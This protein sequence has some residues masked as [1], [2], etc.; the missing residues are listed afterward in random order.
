MKCLR[1]PL[2]TL[3]TLTSCAYRSGGADNDKSDQPIARP[4][5]SAQTAPV[6]HGGDAADDPA[7]WIHPTDPT[8][9]LVLGTDKQGPLVV[10]D[11]DGRVL[12][13]VSETARPDNV[14]VFYD[15]PL[16]GGKADLAV[17]ACRDPKSLGLK[18]WRIDPA[19]RTLADVTAN[20]VIPVFGKTEPYG[21]GTYHSRKTGKHYVFVN[22]KKGQ[23]EQYEL[24]DAGDGKVG[25]KLVRQFKVPS[26]TEGCVADDELGF[27]YIAE[28]AKGIWKFPAEPD[29]GDIGHLI[30]KVG[31]HGLKADVEGL[32]IY[33]APNGKG[34]L[35]ASSQGNNT[36]KV[37]TRDGDNTFVCTI[38]PEGSKAFDDV[39]DTDGIAV[40][41]RPTSAAFSQG[42]FIVQDGANKKGN[43]NFKFYRW[44]DIAVDRLLID[45][46]WDPRK[47]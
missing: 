27:V 22:N 32:A 4:T 47:P 9:S 17:A 3:L 30:A 21:T 7:I 34:Y 44:Q 28:E 23:Q 15:V 35:I 43:Q 6:R 42:L 18:F 29:G 13:T 45:T 36:F 19:T 10:Y 11:M 41:S 5:A 40:T 2:L 38:D 8:R 24:T 46:T 31:Q 16:A 26:T 25:A 33:Y 39:S 1:L 14:D 12:Q 37:Y 20:A